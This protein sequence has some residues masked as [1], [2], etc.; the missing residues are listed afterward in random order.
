MELL[1]S[2]VKNAW[3]KR[4]RSMLTVGG[5][6]VGVMSVVIITIVGDVGKKMVNVELDSMGINGVCLRLP[7][8]IN[9]VFDKHS[10]ELVQQDEQV[11]EATPLLSKVY[12]I[13]VHGVRGQAI[14][15]GVDGNADKIISMDLKY[16]R[17]I[18][19]SDVAQRQNVCVV[20]E[21]FAQK[22]YSRENIVG[23]TV[24]LYLQNQYIDFT[25]VGV[26]SS[27][28]NLMQSIMG[29]V[30]PT[31]LYIPYSTMT[32]YTA[33]NGFTQIVAKVG[34]ETDE[35]TVAAALA[36]RLD[37]SFGISGG[38][39]YENLNGQKENLNSVLNIVAAVLSVI[40]G[41][42]LLVA[43]LSI[44]TVMLVTVSE[45]TREIGIK[46]SIGASK[47]II[48]LEFLFEALS[49]SLFGGIIGALSGLAIGAAGCALIGATVVF[50]LSSVATAIGFAVATGTLFGIYPA[51]KAAELR[52][53]DALRQE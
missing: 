49:M 29:E 11:D 37:Q 4:L 5:I 38:V 43:G 26:V 24:K 47:G 17:L 46:K 12:N 16:G 45:R 7:T 36:Q 19:K 31:F 23:K 40:G 25:V 48:L 33:A 53:V 27:G 9:T 8:D 18:N 42:S 30:V 13:M 52:P 15:W 14:A 28:G 21:T 3:R 51:V 32:Q 34:E 41:I 1:I 50:N 44:M 6:A 22:N 10:L 20:D 2:A 35:N 39:R